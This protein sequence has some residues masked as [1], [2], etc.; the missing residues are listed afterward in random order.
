MEESWKNL[1]KAPMHLVKKRISRE[2]VLAG[3]SKAKMEREKFVKKN[4][5]KVLSFD[6]KISELKKI[7]EEKK[8]AGK[9]TSQIEAKIEDLKKRLKPFKGK[10]P[11]EDARGIRSEIKELEG[12][13]KRL[14]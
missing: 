8:K 1:G 14:G 3:V 9:V 13:V 6:V 5:E 10:V 4:P 7:I 12:E 11:E 2:E